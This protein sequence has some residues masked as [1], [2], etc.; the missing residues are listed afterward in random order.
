M[1]LHAVNS[2]S[3][4]KM[5]L[6]VSLLHHI[7]VRERQY[8]ERPLSRGAILALRVMNIGISLIQILGGLLICCRS[9]KFSLAGAT[10]VVLRLLEMRDSPEMILQ[11]LLVCLYALRF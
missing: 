6:D 2:P 7:P 10:C 4:R 8:E 3:K 9:R 11:K 1:Q 5:P